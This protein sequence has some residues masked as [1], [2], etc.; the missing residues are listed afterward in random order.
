MT[1]L[2]RLFIDPAWT[3]ERAWT[4]LEEANIEILYSSEEEGKIEFFVNISAPNTLAPLP[5]IHACE[6]CSLPSI[7]WEEQWAIHGHDFHDGCVNFDLSTFGRETSLLRL[8]PG[9]GFGDLSHPTTRLI[10]KLMASS[11]CQQTVIDIGCGSGVLTLA[12]AA[13]GALHAY[14]IDIDPEAVKHAQNNALFNHLDSKCQ[15]FSPSDFVWKP[16]AEPVAILMNMIWQEQNTAWKAMSALHEQP[17][18]LFISGVL[19]E[20][21]SRYLSSTKEKRWILQDEKEE[22]GW[23]AF[24]FIT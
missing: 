6:P 12:A 9:A 24:L 13:M 20:E 11:L 1:S 10:V 7:D 3:F 16:S 2:H 18:T 17:A 4:A 14:G 8:K 15:F 19:A 5:W 23:V 22:D 21:R